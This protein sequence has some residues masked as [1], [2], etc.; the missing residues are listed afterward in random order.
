MMDFDVHSHLDY[1]RAQVDRFR[2]MA[3]SKPLQQE[4]VQDK[5]IF[6]FRL[7]FRKRR[8]LELRLVSLCS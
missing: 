4:K 6:S 2:T 8:F 3:K 1:H 5:K 7:P